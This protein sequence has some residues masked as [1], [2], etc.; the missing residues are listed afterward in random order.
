MVTLKLRGDYA[1]ATDR[2]T[3]QPVPV[4]SPLRVGVTVGYHQGRVRANLGG[5]FAFAR[6][7]VP[8]LQTEIPGYANFFANVS[9]AWK[10][11]RSVLPEAFLEGTSLLGQRI[12]YSTSGLKDIT[13]LGRSAVMA[14][15]RGTC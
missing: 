2:S 14:G 12:R 15:L 13:P 8:K 9:Y 7:R 5:L 6:T 3:G 10:L 1:R 11:Q 4:I